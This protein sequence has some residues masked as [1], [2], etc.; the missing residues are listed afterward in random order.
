[1]Y[2]TYQDG[3]D[4]VSKKLGNPADSIRISGGGFNGVGQ[5]SSGGCA[6]IFL[7][8]IFERIEV[9]Y[10]T[11]NSSRKVYRDYFK[12]GA[13]IR[14]EEITAGSSG[15]FVFYPD[16]TIDEVMISMWQNS[17]MTFRF[18]VTGYF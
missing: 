4:T 2:I 16:G 11:D 12:D 5:R 17:T 13:L 15:T 8:D 14:S 1:M 9:A 18:E 3:A 6:R 10:T 7:S